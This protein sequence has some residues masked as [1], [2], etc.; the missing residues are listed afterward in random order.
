[1]WRFQLLCAAA[2]GRVAAHAGSG[3]P[4]FFVLGRR[5]RSCWGALVSFTARSAATVGGRDEA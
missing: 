5:S 2:S 1:M 3:R 4:T